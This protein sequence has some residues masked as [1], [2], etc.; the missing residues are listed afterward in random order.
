MSA[1][2]VKISKSD[3]QMTDQQQIDEYNRKMLLIALERMC[4]TMGQFSVQFRELM[5]KMSDKIDDTKRREE[6]T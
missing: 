1:H 3:T 4:Q 5:N 6:L 2:L